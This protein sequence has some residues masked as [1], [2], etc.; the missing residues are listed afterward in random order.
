MF[1]ESTAIHLCM[2]FKFIVEAQ[3]DLSPQH[4]CLLV[5]HDLG[6]V[7]QSSLF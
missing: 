3:I 2:L 7:A 1:L 6:E 4:L 5:L